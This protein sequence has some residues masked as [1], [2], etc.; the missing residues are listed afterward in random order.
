MLDNSPI[1]EETE[2]SIS[3]EQI[4]SD[5]LSYSENSEHGVNKDMRI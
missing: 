4:E 1:L 3:T 5:N 2:K